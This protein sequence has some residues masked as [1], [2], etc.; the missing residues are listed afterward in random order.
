MATFIYL[1]NINKN[2]EPVDEYKRF[3]MVSSSTTT[4]EEYSI[5]HQVITSMSDQHDKTEFEL[6]NNTKL[7]YS[8]KSIHHNEK[9]NHCKKSQCSVS[10]CKATNSERIAQTFLRDKLG[11]NRMDNNVYKDDILLNDSNNN[12]NNNNDDGWWI[13]EIYYVQT[14]KTDIDF[15]YD[16]SF[17]YYGVEI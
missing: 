2:Q 7:F 5:G 4:S 15:E 6:Q 1:R 11:I 13:D 17:I 10:L 12:N 8:D 9:N 16:P 14:S 3:E